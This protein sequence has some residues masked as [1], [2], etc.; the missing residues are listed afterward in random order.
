MPAFPVHGAFNQGA[1]PLIACINR[2]TIYSADD[3]GKLVPAL[4]KFLDDC[5]VPIWGTPASLTLASGDVPGAWSLVM[6][7]DADA[8]DA[9][10]YHDLTK[11]G[12][13]I[14]KVFIKTTLAAGEKISMTACHELAEMLIDPAANLWAQHP[15]G[16][17][18]AY[19]ACDACEEEEFLIDG[20]AMS[21]FVTPAYFEGFRTRGSARFDYLHK[22]VHPFEILRGGYAITSEAGKVNN[23]FGSEAKREKFARED[24]RYHRSEY[25]QPITDTQEIDE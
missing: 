9:L 25:R 16:A 19:E 5:F 10:G 21:D 17:M 24:R 8:A 2:S 18:F 3:M 7:D 1:A 13:P 23:V 12:L 4:R 20:I 6:L 15:K 22:I 14:S 11:D